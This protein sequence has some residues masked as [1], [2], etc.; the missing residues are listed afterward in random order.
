MISSSG[1]TW[2]VCDDFLVP[3]FVVESNSRHSLC[4]ARVLP[5]SGESDPAILVAISLFAISLCLW[6][7]E[8]FVNNRISSVDCLRNVSK[9]AREREMEK[10]GF[11]W[12]TRYNRCV[13]FLRALAE[14]Y[15]RT[16]VWHRQAERILLEWWKMTHGSHTFLGRATTVTSQGWIGVKNDRSAKILKW[17]FL[18]T[19]NVSLLF[20]HSMLSNPGDVSLQGESVFHTYQVETNK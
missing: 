6:C 15:R 1:N 11:L 18:K 2:L 8:M 3:P 7:G 12:P 10:L 13:S 9:V 19:Y 5:C 4:I 16:R 17:Y 14:H 20:I